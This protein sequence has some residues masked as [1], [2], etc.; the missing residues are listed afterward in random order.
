MDDAESFI[1]T[2][3]QLTE[4]FRCIAYSL[5]TGKGDGA[6]LR[7]YSHANLVEDAIALLDGLGIR[8]TYVFGSSFG[9][10]I[11]LAAMHARPDRIARAVLQGGFARRPLA[12]A[13]VML[14]RLCRYLPGPAGALPLRTSILRHVHSK[15]FA[16]RPPELWD[17]FVALGRSPD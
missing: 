15:H 1:L 7:R 6:A 13:E 3:A 4:E 11:A 14:A 8:Q 16:G 10:T 2:V 12:P 17:H 5:P 9:S